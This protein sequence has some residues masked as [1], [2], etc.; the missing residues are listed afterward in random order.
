M[1]L[2][3]VATGDVLMGGWFFAVLL[4]S[5]VALMAREW[6]GLAGPLSPAAR[7]FVMGAA[8]LPA[9]AILLAMAGEADGAV[10]LLAVGS[11]AAAGVAALLPGAPAHWAA[12]GVLYVGL[13]ALS[14]LWLRN[15]GPNG[16][17]LVLWLFFVVWATDTCAYFFGRA[18]GGP[19]LAPRLSP[20]KTWAGLAG[21]MAGAVAVGAA[22]AA[23]QGGATL[24]AGALAALL[25]VVAQ[26]GDLFE[27]WLKRR[28]GLKDSGTLIP[29]HGG[30]FDRLDGLLFA[31]P[32]FAAIVLASGAR[33]GG[34]AA[35]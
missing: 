33:G 16:I 29:G 19:R 15:D 27:S 25:A 32:V 18:I 21:G 24:A 20:S 31:A 8:L 22:F 35:P 11:V 12:G 6:A 23:A 3:L 1:L 30:V 7:D 26:G 2:G 17:V 5:A 4:L 28:V 34:G 9:A 10:L 13:P 14:L